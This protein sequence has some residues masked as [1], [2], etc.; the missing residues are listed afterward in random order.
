M[1]ASSGAIALIWLGLM[2]STKAGLPLIV[3]DTPSSLTGRLPAEK[4][5]DVQD[6]EAVANPVPTIET[7]PP[8]E[9][10]GW[11]LAALT[12][13]LIREVA[14]GSGCSRC[15]RMPSNPPSVTWNAGEPSL[16]RDADAR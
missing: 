15:R 14:A 1:V 8:D 9:I 11:K 6:R 12:T 16:Y 4:S 3:T 5:D 10:A 2:Y 7:N 13:E